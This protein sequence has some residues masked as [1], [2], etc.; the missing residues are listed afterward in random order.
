MQDLGSAEGG[1]TPRIFHLPWLDLILE[2]PPNAQ[3]KPHTPL[4]PSIHSCNHSLLILTTHHF[5]NGSTNA[6]IPS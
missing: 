6:I 2:A 3:I 1:L 4:F 5:F